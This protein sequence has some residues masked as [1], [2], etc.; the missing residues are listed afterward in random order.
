VSVAKRTMGSAMW[1]ASAGAAVQAIA[2]VGNIVVARY[3]EDGDY[4]V[5]AGAMVVVAL[6]SVFTSFGFVPAIVSGRLAGES[7]LRTAHWMMGASGLVLAGIAAACGPLAAYF[8]DEPGMTA[9]IVAGA[10]ILVLGA[11][12]ATPQAILQAAGKFRVIAAAT[13]AGQVAASIAAIVMAVMGAGV[14]ALVA[15]LIVN[16]AVRAVVCVA[17]C[18]A[19]LKPRWRPGDVKPFAREGVH[20]I[21]TSIS[22]FVFFSADKVIIG[23]LLGMDP[24]GRYTFGQTLVNRAMTAFTR[25]LSSPLLSSLGTLRDQRE[26]FDRGVV[27]SCVAVGRLSLPIG[28][29][30]ALLAEP[31]IRV[32]VGEKWL[33]ATLLV[34][35][36][37]I[38]SALQA[39]GQ[40]VA[41]VWQSLGH[42]GQFFKLSLASNIA[43]ALALLG[44]ALVG[45]VEAAA[46]AYAATSVLILPVHV[47]LVRRVCGL[48]LAGL[49]RG[50]LGIMRDVAVMTGAVWGLGMLLADSG[51]PEW[52]TLAV[53]VIAGAAVYALMFRFCSGAEL[54]ELCSA[55]P[56]PVRSLSERVFMIQ[57]RSGA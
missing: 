44:G 56:G 30:G 45:S 51:L 35:V 10:A 17:L 34:Q 21:G 36:F 52:L 38:L 53:R 29:G 40:L 25:S 16:G 13:V 28:A 57:A 9:V 7:A 46:L 19:S 41:P 6:A 3:L 22:D 55:L 26:R 32:L 50:M 42:T 20:V 37:F 24:L 15:P 43:M 4:G 2:L 54:R 31:M 48:S 8:F 18:P 47:Y 39:L 33:P 49:S 5:V 23:K 27:R 11:W 14:W 12:E 1:L